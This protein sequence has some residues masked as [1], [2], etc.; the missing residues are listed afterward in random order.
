MLAPVSRLPSAQLLRLLFLCACLAVLVASVMPPDRLPSQLNN[1]WDKIQHVIAYGG[2]AFLGRLAWPRSM[3]RVVVGLLVMGSLI[4][5]LQAASGWRDGSL[6]DIVANA[7]GLLAMTG[8]M[9]V[10]RP[11]KPGITA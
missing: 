11:A 2:L 9:H 5:L 10:V 6:Q 4:E 7:V 8:L 3:L 1:G